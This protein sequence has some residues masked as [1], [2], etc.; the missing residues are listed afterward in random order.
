MDE[1]LLLLLVGGILAGSILVALGCCTNGAARALGVPGDRDAARLRRPRRDRVRRR[2]A[3]AGG[4]RG[5]ARA[6]PLRGRPADVV[7]APARGRGA[8]GAPEHRRRGRQ[9]RPDRRRRVHALRSHLAR[10]RA[11]RRRRLLDRRG[12]RLRD[13]PVHAHPPPPRAH[14]RGRVGRQRPDGDRTHARPD[15]LDRAARHLWNRRPAPARRP[16]ARS[17]PR[18]RGRARR[19]RV[20]GL[21]PSAALDRRFRARGIA[22]GGGARV[23]RRRRDRRQRLPLGLPGRPRG[24]QHAVPLPPPPRLVPRGARVRGPGRA[25]HRPRSARLPL[26]P[27]RRRHPGTGARGCC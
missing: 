25:L 14:A 1:G 11:A 5:R 16:A 22:R 26:R 7:A 2:E 27:A 6:D 10:V 23:R 20:M 21:R 9:C 19:G 4:R 24:R 12:R 13:A 3:R 18:R 8:C 17:R 15:R